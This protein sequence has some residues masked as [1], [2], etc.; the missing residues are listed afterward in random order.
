MNDNQYLSR[1]LA[2]QTFADDS[3]EMIEMQS[4]RANV[5]KIL[6]DKYGTSPCIRYGGSKMKG[7]MI[8]ASF[9]LDIHCYFARDDTTPGETLREIYDN[10]RET[11]GNEFTVEPKKT[12]LRLTETALGLKSKKPNQ[13]GVYLHVDVVPGRYI[14]GEDGDVFVHQNEGDKERMKTNLITHRDHI[15]DSGVRDAIRLIK[16]WNVQNGTSLKT[17]VLEL[18]VVDLLKGHKSNTLTDQL[19]RVWTAFRDESD[20]L[21]VSDP[22][23]SNNNLKP[24]L[25]EKRSLLA[26]HAALT[27]Q[28]IEQSGWNVVYGPVDESDNDKAERLQNLI[29]TVPSG[30]RHKPYGSE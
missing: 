20:A 17:F 15:R 18:L 12:A 26:S 10:V 22:A 27:L 21:N 24:A 7:T 5:E 19:T 16:L 6:R 13:M 23:N 9:D 2:A 1:V 25:D 11:L 4:Q 8:C 30:Q 29:M 3:P 14:D 28:S